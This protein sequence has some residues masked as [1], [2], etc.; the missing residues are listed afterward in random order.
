MTE[1]LQ[2]TKPKYRRFGRK[3]LQN[4]DLNQ[5]REVHFCLRELIVMDPES[6]HFLHF[7]NKFSHLSVYPSHKKAFRSQLFECLAT[8]CNKTMNVSLTQGV[9][10]QNSRLL[11][12]SEGKILLFIPILTLLKTLNY[13]VGNFIALILSL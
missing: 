2:S 13:Y 10:V 4:L 1:I 8:L 3:S 6:H 5:T 11:V 12:V 9:P 7:Q